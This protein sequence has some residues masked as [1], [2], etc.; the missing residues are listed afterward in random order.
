MDVEITNKFI[1]AP[2]YEEIK[3]RPSGKKVSLA[4]L[5]DEEP[6]LF[7]QLLGTAPFDEAS[8]IFSAL[9]DYH[10]KMGDYD[11][12][13]CKLDS[14]LQINLEICKWCQNSQECSLSE[15]KP[16]EVTISIN[17]YGSSRDCTEREVLNMYFQNKLKEDSLIFCTDGDPFSPQSREKVTKTLQLFNPSEYAIP[18]NDGKQCWHHLFY[19]PL[20]KRTL[21]IFETQIIELMDHKKDTRKISKRYAFPTGEE[22]KAFLSS[23]N[24]SKPTDLREFDIG[25]FIN[26]NEKI[27]TWVSHIDKYSK[28]GLYK[29]AIELFTNYSIEKT[30]EQNLSDYI[31]EIIN[32]IDMAEDGLLEVQSVAARKACI[33][34][35]PRGYEQELGLSF[36]H[37]ITRI[38]ELDGLEQVLVLVDTEIKAIKRT[39]E[40]NSQ[41]ITKE[42]WNETSDVPESL[43]FIFKN[44][45]LKTKIIDWRHT[46]KNNKEHSEEEYIRSGELIKF[47]PVYTAWFS[48]QEYYC[49][50]SYHNYL[51]QTTAS[52]GDKEYY[53]MRTNLAH[54]FEYFY[55][56]VEGDLKLEYFRDTFKAPQNRRLKGYEIM[57]KLSQFQHKI[58][59]AYLIHDSKTDH[60]TNTTVET[61]IFTSPT[62]K[63]KNLQTLKWTFEMVRVELKAKV[64]QHHNYN[65]N[66]IFSFSESGVTN[67]LN[68]LGLGNK[69]A[70][71]LS[72]NPNQKHI[73]TTKG[74]GIWL[75]AKILQL[76]EQCF[77]NN[78]FDLG[79]FIVDRHREWSHGR[80]MCIS[81]SDELESIKSLTGE[82]SVSRSIQ[83]LNFNI[84]GVDYQLCIWNP[85]TAAP[86]TSPSTFMSGR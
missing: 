78:Y 76:I 42:F 37:Q 33:L 62:L 24:L 11:F 72:W 73:I 50:L 65:K 81:L 56:A 51:R 40:T 23:E 47:L 17:L 70:N 82:S 22:V 14:N 5:Y 74:G 83:Q 43:N 16:E 41:L 1:L 58:F 34:Y 39:K 46:N 19:S 20:L 54:F 55:P 79:H 48:P 68:L 2:E 45:Q 71:A 9:K 18:F 10:H 30:I 57:Y 84:N 29:P 13:T 3:L 69:L 25:E 53:S 80:V 67:D 32:A 36:S 49:A 60:V 8:A 35:V 21:C 6:Q 26:S 77:L 7:A 4:K 61:F 31:I 59:N 86:E 64:E 44:S 15:N 12:S 75:S 52:S 85:E 28:T 63:D 66:S 27:G 38:V